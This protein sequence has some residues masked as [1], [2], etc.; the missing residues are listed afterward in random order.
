[1][2]DSAKQLLDEIYDRAVDWQRMS[3]NDMKAA[4]DSIAEDIE[5]WRNSQEPEEQETV[6]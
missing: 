4:L 2:Q 6:R 1:M 3:V 5:I